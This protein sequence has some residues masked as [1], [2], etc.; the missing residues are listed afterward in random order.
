MG[1]RR[2][3]L[4]TCSQIPNTKYMKRLL[5]NFLI[6]L[7]ALWAASYLVPTFTV[8]GGWR[9]FLIG[10]LVFMFI[11][12]FVKP[13][14]RLAFLP[15]NLLTMGI[16]SWLINVIGFYVLTLVLPQFKITPFDFAGTNLGWVTLPSAH[17]NI[18]MVAIVA[19]FLI[20][21]ITNLLKWLCQG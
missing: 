8:S 17:L 16:F 19:S 13:L 12:I 6:T 7:V 11:D 15:I 2:L 18:F 20:G 21:L 3:T 4:D 14:V 9:A 5:R 10:T 1:L